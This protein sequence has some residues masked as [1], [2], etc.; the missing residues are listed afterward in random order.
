MLELD[1]DDVD[2]ITDFVSS[3]GTEEA[4]ASTPDRTWKR[5][6]PHFF[7]G[8]AALAVLAAIMALISA[9]AK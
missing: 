3:M 8:M 2:S 4:D 9:I 5:W 6:I 7:V 1:P